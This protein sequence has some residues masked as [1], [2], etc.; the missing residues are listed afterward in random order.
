M[1]ETDS[2]PPPEAPWTPAGGASDVDV[3]VVDPEP[4]PAADRKPLNNSASV[5][6]T[7]LAAAPAATPAPPLCTPISDA[8]VLLASCD[9]GLLFETGDGADAAPWALPAASLSKSCSRLEAS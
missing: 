6:P 9:D 3:A 5:E 2:P 7:V 1:L 8:K 4:A